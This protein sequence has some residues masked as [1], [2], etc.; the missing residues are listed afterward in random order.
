MKKLSLIVATLISTNAFAYNTYVAKEST[1]TELKEAIASEGK[2]LVKGPWIFS[3]FLY[4]S[5][6]ACNSFEKA[7][8][9]HWKTKSGRCTLRWGC[10]HD[11]SRNR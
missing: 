3:R 1:C 5:P 4:D 2:V 7:V 9:T 6:S 11:N 8:T 10:E